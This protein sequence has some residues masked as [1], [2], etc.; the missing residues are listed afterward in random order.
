MFGRRKYYAAACSP[1]E[2]T[3]YSVENFCFHESSVKNKI[4]ERCLISVNIDESLNKTSL[5]K[6]ENQDFK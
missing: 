2:Y 6:I 3:L 4:Y 5:R 1:Q